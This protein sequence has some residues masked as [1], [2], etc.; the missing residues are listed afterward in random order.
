MPTD[1]GSDS[2]SVG[3]AE[4]GAAE[5]ERW[6]KQPD[7]LIIGMGTGRTLRPDQTVATR[8]YSAAKRL[9]SPRSCN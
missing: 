5:L 8:A 4:A 1:P 7:P 6:L 3:V 9:V 2:V